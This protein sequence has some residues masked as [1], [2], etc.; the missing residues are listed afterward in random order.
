MTHALVGLF[1]DALQVEPDRLDETSSPATVP[2]WD[3]TANMILIAA[4][5]ETYEIALTTA[6]IERMHS[7]GAVRD[8]L[9]GKGAAVT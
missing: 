3:S 4:I 5:E 1:A 7:I 8:I 9:R 2:E 6:E